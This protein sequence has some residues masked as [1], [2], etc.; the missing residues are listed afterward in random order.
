MATRFLF[1]HRCKMVGFFI[2]AVAFLFGIIFNNYFDGFWVVDVKF[3]TWMK[4]GNPASFSSVDMT[5]TI[6]LFLFITGG[7]LA[8]FSKEKVEDEFV[9]SLRLSSLMWAVFINYVILLLAVLF[10]YGLNFINVLMFNT[11]TIL[12]IFIVR[13]NYLFFRYSRTLP[14]EK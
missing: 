12:L 6:T 9:S 7:L 14:D 8:A 13:F 5:L 11:V 10:I 1:P 2:L 4:A 3:L